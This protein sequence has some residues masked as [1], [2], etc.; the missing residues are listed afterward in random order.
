MVNKTAGFACILL[1]CWMP[2]LFVPPNPNVTWKFNLTMQH[3]DCK[4]CST[5]CEKTLGD[6][7][8]LVNS[9]MNSAPNASLLGGGIK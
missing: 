6:M 2:C 3:V 4:V 7:N 1:T 9:A 5:L 8:G